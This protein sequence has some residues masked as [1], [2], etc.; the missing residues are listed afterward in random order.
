VIPDAFSDALPFSGGL[1][2]VGISKT[3]EETGSP[4]WNLSGGSW[5]FI[6]T[7]GKV[8]IPAQFAMAHGFSDGLAAVVT[9]SEW[10]RAVAEGGNIAKARPKWGFIDA[11]GEFVLE[12]RFLAA[13]DFR[14]GLASVTL[15][16]GK[17]AYID[18]TGATVWVQ[19]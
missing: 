14:G 19:P 13:N 6:D 11:S 2:A 1:A 15:S 18:T 9:E 7:T 3:S 10:T 17:K 16:D 4:E 12:P 8:A 5:G